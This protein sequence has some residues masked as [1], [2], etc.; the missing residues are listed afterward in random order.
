ML[1]SSKAS[2]DAADAE[3]E[4]ALDASGLADDYGKTH[5]GQDTSD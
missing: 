5:E 2:L 4:D 1:N 3:V